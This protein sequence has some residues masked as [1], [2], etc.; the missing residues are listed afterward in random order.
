MAT[1]IENWSHCWNERK[2]D[3]VLLKVRGD[4]LSSTDHCLIY[5][6]TEH[7]ISLI[8]DGNLEQQVISKMKAAG[9]PIVTEKP[10]GENVRSRMIND[11]LI[12]DRLPGEINAAIKEYDR[13]HPEL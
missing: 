9:V 2:G 7:S 10:R 6:A 3:Y 1:E 5:N 4:D 8:E 13:L 12:A 11:M